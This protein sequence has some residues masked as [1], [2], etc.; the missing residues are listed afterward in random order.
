[1]DNELWDAGLM[2]VFFGVIAATAIGWFVVG[3][4]TYGKGDYL[5]P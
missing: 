2:V 1:M 3:I 4:F 5:Q